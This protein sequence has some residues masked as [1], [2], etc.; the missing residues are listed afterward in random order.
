[1]LY[2][3]SLITLFTGLVQPTSISLEDNIGETVSA[4]YCRLNHNYA[5]YDRFFKTLGHRFIA[6]D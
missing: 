2:W 5:D 3:I 1:M 6:E 4:I